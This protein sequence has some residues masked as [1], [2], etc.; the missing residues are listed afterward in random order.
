M[1]TSELDILGSCM[2]SF[3]FYI[4]GENTEEGGNGDVCHCTY[5]HVLHY[6][7]AARSQVNIL[8]IV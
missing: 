3:F 8:L 7:S 2:L 6:V 5:Y 4:G 1:S